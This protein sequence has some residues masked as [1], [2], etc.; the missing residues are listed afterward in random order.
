MFGH[1]SINRKAGD[2]LENIRENFNRWLGGIYICDD[3]TGIKSRI[4]L[5]SAS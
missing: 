3:P 2:A 4:G 1:F 5:V